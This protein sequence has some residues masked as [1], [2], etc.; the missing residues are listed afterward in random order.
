MCGLFG[1]IAREP[2]NEERASAAHRVQAHRGP[3]AE[4]S[5]RATA[6]P[7]SVYLGHQRLAIIDLSDAGRQP[8]QHECGAVVAFNGEIYNYVELREQLEREGERFTSHSDTEVLLKAFVRWG[9]PEALRKCNG[10]WAIAYV[11]PSLGKVFLTRDRCGEKPLYYTAVED[12][13]AFASEI[14]TLLALTGKRYAVNHQVTAE[15]LEQAVLDGGCETFLSGIRQVPA[16]TFLTIDLRTRQI[17]PAIAYWSAAEAAARPPQGNVVE[18]LRHLFDE[19]VRIRLRSDVPVG[20]LVSGGL[21]SSAI[22]AA[23]H[24]SVGA[25]GDL[26]LLSAVS[27][28]PRFDESQYARC[29]AR[30]LG[31]ELVEV[32]LDLRADNAL[33]L[34]TRACYVNDEPVGTFSAVA[35]YLL[36]QQARAAGITVVLSGQGGDELLCGYRKYLGFHLQ[37]L[38]RRGRLFEA[39]R[40]LAQ[41]VRQGTVVTQFS[42]GEAGRYLPRFLHDASA[43][44]LG[45]AL[46]S[47]QR[48][49]LGLSA[50]ATV[51]MRQASDVSTFSVPALTHYEDRM[52]MAWAREIRLPFLDSALLDL[53]LAAP[54]QTKLHN[55]WTKYALRQIMSERLPAQI[56][57][58]RDKQ[59]FSTPQSEWLRTTLSSRLDQLFAE[60]CLMYQ[61]RLVDPVA[62]RRLYAQYKKLPPGSDRIGLRRIFAPLALEL[63][64][65]SYESSLAL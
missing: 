29:V 43:S 32:R 14:K 45:S 15:Y 17:A 10:M 41:F 46:E 49:S 62:L 40:A 9:V 54:T 65:R 12:G 18:R 13:V 1:S 25:K 3:D 36:M 50:G 37:E 24:Q 22:A 51:Q 39:A 55:G 53:M 56:V 31:R 33:D 59:G 48:R 8:M 38:V 5:W 57:W 42:L 61:A 16:G 28:D 4:G 26:T 34:L 60:N 47:F 23:A 21:D 35:H 30:H 19:A 2:L 6:G 64:L 27:D 52:S 11:E 20:I 44:V 58:R 63:W 7:S